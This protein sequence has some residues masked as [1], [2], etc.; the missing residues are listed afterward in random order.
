MFAPFAET[1]KYFG[2]E[3]QRYIRNFRVRN[4]DAMVAQLRRADIKV[5]VD[6]QTYPNGR[7]AML[8]DPESNPI[9]LWEPKHP[10]K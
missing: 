10:R 9:Q 3:E 5:E 7:F 4:M 8:H 1:S 2:R 6:P